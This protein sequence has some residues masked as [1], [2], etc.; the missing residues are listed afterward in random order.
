MLFPIKATILFNMSVLSQNSFLCI[1][2]SYAK[3]YSYTKSLQGNLQI[4]RI[5]A[6]TN[7]IMLQ[8]VTSLMVILS[9]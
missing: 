6:A 8:I 2:N 9:R 1:L 5:E 7:D 4:P 3:F